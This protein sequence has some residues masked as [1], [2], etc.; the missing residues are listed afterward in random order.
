MQLSG[1]LNHRPSSR[2]IVSVVR[3]ASH[4]KTA[5]REA[6]PPEALVFVDVCRITLPDGLT[7]VQVTCFAS[8]LERM[9]SPSG[10]GL[11]N[12]PYAV[13]SEEI[14]RRVPDTGIMDGASAMTDS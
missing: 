1:P 12:W 14:G 8:A 6:G 11:T 7:S 10:S 5:S 4:R 3:G 13:P 2:F 9:R